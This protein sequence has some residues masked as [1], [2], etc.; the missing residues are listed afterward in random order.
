MLHS[1]DD[2]VLAKEHALAMLDALRGI[3]NRYAQYKAAPR[4]VERERMLTGLCLE[5]CKVTELLSALNL[6]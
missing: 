5:A 6:R 3:A 4:G 2:K 1:L